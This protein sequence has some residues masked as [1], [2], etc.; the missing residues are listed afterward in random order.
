MHQQALRVGT[1]GQMVAGQGCRS[2]AHLDLCFFMRSH[3]GKV[4]VLPDRAQ[5]T[6]PPHPKKNYLLSE[7]TSSPPL[8][9][10][11]HKICFLAINSS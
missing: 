11:S 2:G 7:G 8:L 9:K 4:G 5:Q 10:I 6:A 1:A 3:K